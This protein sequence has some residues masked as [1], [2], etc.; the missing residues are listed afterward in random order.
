MNRKL[1]C[2]NFIYVTINRCLPAQIR[3]LLSKWLSYKRKSPL[4]TLSS[5]V[6]NNRMVNIFLYFQCFFI[7]RLNAICGIAKHGKKNFYYILSKLMCVCI[8]LYIVIKYT[9]ILFCCC[10]DLFVECCRWRARASSEP[11]RFIATKK[12]IMFT[13]H[14]NIKYQLLRNCAQ[15]LSHFY[16]VIVLL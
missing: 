2:V 16:S 8:Y 7:S 15:F 3:L 11:K 13:W 12:M 14:I 10:C 4:F 6:Y 5:A 9:M 1:F